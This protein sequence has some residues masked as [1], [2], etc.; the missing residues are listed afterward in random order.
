MT[1][2]HAN[3]LFPW[4]RANLGKTALGPLTGNDSRCLLAAVMIVEAYSYNPCDELAQAFAGCVRKMQPSTWDLAFHCIA[5]VMNWEDRP[6]LWHRAGLSPDLKV[7]K[8]AWE[9]GG[10]A[11]G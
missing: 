6:R 7:S 9:P 8:C 11:R 4:L 10:S 5:H 3:T 2:Y 1:K